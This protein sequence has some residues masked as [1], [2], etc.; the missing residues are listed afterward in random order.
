[1]KNGNHLRPSTL[2]VGGEINLVLQF[3]HTIMLNREQEF[4]SRYLPAIA[5]LEYTDAF[6]C[7]CIHH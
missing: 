6:A 5:Y 1:M 2:R 7:V 3:F 4:S